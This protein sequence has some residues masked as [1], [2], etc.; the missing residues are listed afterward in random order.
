MS[1][2][3]LIFQVIDETGQSYLGNIICDLISY[4]SHAYSKF[5]INGS[6]REMM[7][8][9]IRV[10]LP[11]DETIK[12]HLIGHR[13][14]RIADSD[15]KYDYVIDQAN[16]KII[17]RNVFVSY[18]AICA[19]TGIVSMKDYDDD[20]EIE[21]DDE[22]EIEIGEEMEDKKD[23][24]SQEFIKEK[25]EDATKRISFWTRMIAIEHHAA[26]ENIYKMKLFQLK[27]K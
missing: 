5:E 21:R 6:Y 10:W 2:C 13:D 19:K 9:Y 20:E 26:I 27:H 18:N 15:L 24:V 14:R 25:Y 7:T 17:W 11:D 3:N 1:H 23:K 22:M 8:N 4:S 12:I 16:R